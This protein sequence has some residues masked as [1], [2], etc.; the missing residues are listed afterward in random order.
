MT[1]EATKASVM[2]TTS[3]E[4]VPIARV[5]KEGYQEEEGL[6]RPE[7]GRQLPVERLGTACSLKAAREDLSACQSGFLGEEKR[8][9]EEMARSKGVKCSP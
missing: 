9:D 2:S 4:R 1:L 8:D 6:L 7:V 5:L 3:L